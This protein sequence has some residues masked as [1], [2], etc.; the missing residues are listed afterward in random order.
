[1]RAIRLGRESLAL[2]KRSLTLSDGRRTSVALEPAFWDVLEKIALLRRKT[3]T[4][5][6][7]DVDRHRS[8]H[9]ALTSALRVYALQH[10]PNEF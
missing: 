8:D 3:I 4:A 2:Q 1:M 10:R 5:L 6:V 9:A 7:S